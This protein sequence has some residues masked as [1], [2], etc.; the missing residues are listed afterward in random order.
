MAYQLQPASNLT[1]HAKR[2]ALGLSNHFVVR[3]KLL[4][5]EHPS[6]RGREVVRCDD[7]SRHVWKANGPRGNP[8]LRSLLVL[9]PTC[10]R[11]GIHRTIA[12]LSKT[13]DQQEKADRTEVTL[14]SYHSERQETAWHSFA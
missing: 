13:G 1:M 4:A 14:A 10:V 3:T 7:P 11:S 12:I 2:P 6:V 9:F 5:C 8:L